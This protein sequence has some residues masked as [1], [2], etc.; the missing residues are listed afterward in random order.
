MAGE[1]P[2]HVLH[3]HVLTDPVSH[4]KLCL[5][6][7]YYLV[8]RFLTQRD[9]A[10]LLRTSRDMRE[11]LTPLLYKKDILSVKSIYEA[12]GFQHQD[13][14]VDQVSQSNY[15]GQ[16]SPLARKHR[17]LPRHSSTRR[18]QALHWACIIGSLRMVNQI[19]PQA[20][21]LY[22]PYID[23]KDQF[24]A[25]PLFLA[26]KYQNHEIVVALVQAGCYVDA[27]VETEVYIDSTFHISNPIWRAG[28][29]ND[30]EETTALAFSIVERQPAVAK[31]LAK[32]T[33]R[34]YIPY[35]DGLVSVLDLASLEGMVDVVRILIQ[36][37]MGPT[38]DKSEEHHR[39]AQSL[40]FAATRTNNVEV[41][42][43]LVQNGA[44][45]A[46]Q[47]KFNKSPLAWAIIN[48]HTANALYLV[49]LENDGY[50][51]SRIIKGL[52]AST[53]R[54]RN[55]PITQVLVD[56]LVAADAIREIEYVLHQCLYRRATVPLTVQYLLHMLA[57]KIPKM[58][59]GHKQSYLHWALVQEDGVDEIVVHFFIETCAW[60]VDLRA[61]DDKGKT[62]L[63]YAN[64]FMLRDIAEL[65]KKHCGDNN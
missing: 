15:D 21:G 38:L 2:N 35:R 17:E 6:V 20:L 49:Q 61:K 59:W 46:A 51:G 36:R 7:I 56:R 3:Q 50:A 45:H 44:N 14:R 55:L 31:I 42:K 28:Q 37:E 58:C 24:N 64:K 43:V 48:S 47:D 30:L 1:Q 52:R 32:H 19:I 29:R 4:P 62:A 8:D 41:M 53:Q 13:D 22:K 34:P 39:G 23:S 11:L 33:R 5:D 40:H 10:S 26:V 27:P 63:Y 9:A 65:I 16:D 12:S 57:V 54:D 25:T 60:L 18:P